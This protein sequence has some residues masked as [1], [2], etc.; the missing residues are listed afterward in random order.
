M[1]FLLGSSVY[2][3]T[4][5]IR[6][7]EYSYESRAHLVRNIV[8]ENGGLREFSYSDYVDYVVT[9]E[10][11]NKDA[12]VLQRLA[13]AYRSGKIIVFPNYF[14]DCS[15][16][17]SL[18]PLSEEYVYRAPLFANT[19]IYLS[20]VFSD[21]DF[22]KLCSLVEYHHGKC[23]TKLNSS[24]THMVFPGNL[25]KE[26]L[27]KISSKVRS[28]S[29]LPLCKF[30]TVSWILESVRNVEVK[31]WEDYFPVVGSKPVHVICAPSK[32]I[33]IMSNSLEPILDGNTGS[34]GE[35][36][37]PEQAK[38]CATAS[39]S[40][41]NEPNVFPGNTESVQYTIPEDYKRRNELTLRLDCEERGG[42]K[43][44]SKCKNI[45]DGEKENSLKKGKAQKS[46]NYRNPRPFLKDVTFCFYNFGDSFKEI[47]AKALCMCGANVIEPQS[48]DY[49]LYGKTRP[50]YIL[51]SYEE[52]VRNY[53]ESESEGV[54]FMSLHWLHHILIKQELLESN[55]PLHKPLRGR[56]SLNAGNDFFI[57]ITG[58]E[59]EERQQAKDMIKLLGFVYTPYLSP[60]NTHLLCKKHDIAIADVPSL[61]PLISEHM[62]GDCG[63]KVIKA[64]EWNIELV[65]FSWLKDMVREWKVL[66]CDKYRPDNSD[67]K[68]F[69]HPK[70]HTID[71]SANIGVSSEMAQKGNSVRI[72][73]VGYK[74]E[75]SEDIAKFGEFVNT[76]GGSVVESPFDCTHVVVKESNVQNDFLLSSKFLAVYSTKRKRHFVTGAWISACLAE[77][78]FKEIDE[79][80]KFDIEKFIEDSQPQLVTSPSA[81][82]SARPEKM[83]P[84]CMFYFL[85]CIEPERRNEFERILFAYGGGIFTDVLD[86]LECAVEVNKKS[87]VIIGTDSVSI[88]PIKRSLMTVTRGLM[89]A[90]HF[91]TEIFIAKCILSKNVSFD[92]YKIE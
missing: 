50:L 61:H 44:A 64:I 26:Q 77:G 34:E 17:R 25:T 14:I 29:P 7:G 16:A 67:I 54:Q 92:Y 43:E 36:C 40:E 12:E 70:G 66:P 86:V 27:E 78:K 84:L 35:V 42:K 69:L 37:G 6:E 57:S 22:S 48:V 85:P 83:F 80:F 88:S 10:C 47:W 19:V 5:F 1:H 13:E 55:E 9:S 20:G 51:S 45:R 87:I 82:V 32:S 18:L 91:H 11:M 39:S 15:E 2:L 52:D 68:R 63:G 89:H 65:C 73:F 21:Q 56:K 3:E 76:I 53:F 23:A 38:G 79:A 30:V 75:D 33:P 62:L 58:L 81:N 8:G 31:S 46:C 24:V 71:S 72:L 28:Y 74:K 4:D 60:G 49:S 59:G 41:D 90:V